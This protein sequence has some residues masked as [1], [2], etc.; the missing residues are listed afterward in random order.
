M[1]TG[2]SLFTRRLI[3]QVSR[4]DNTSSLD[5]SPVHSVLELFTGM[6][7]LRDSD[8]DSPSKIDVK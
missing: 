6:W 1:K 3:C 8:K 5:F 7:Q 4:I 2:Q